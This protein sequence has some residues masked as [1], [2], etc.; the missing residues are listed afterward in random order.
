ML[1][2][3][4][5]VLSGHPSSFFTPQPIE[6]PSTLALSPTLCAHLHPGEVSSLNDLAHLAFQ[7]TSIR[8][9][10]RNIQA[11]GRQSVLEASLQQQSRYKIKG[12]GKEKE[13]TSDGVPAVDLYL[14]TLAGSVLDILREYEYLIVE[15]EARVINSD[16]GLVQDEGGYVPLS[17]L[18][19][20]FSPWQAPLASLSSLITTLP[21]TP[22]QMIQHLTDLA[23]NGNPRINAIYSS[24]LHAVHRL[25]LTHLIVFLLSGTAPST[26]TP[27]S[28]AVGL[29]AGPDPLSPQ[30]RIYKLND[31]LFPPSIRADTRESILY[32]GRVTATLKREGRVLPKSLLDGLRDAILTSNNLTLD[33]AIQRAREEVGE[34]LWTHVLTSSQVCESIDSFGD[35]F[36]TRKADYATSLLRE[37][38]ALQRTKLLNTNPHSSTA[39]IREQDLNTAILRASVGTCAELDRNVERLRYRLLQGSIRPLSMGHATA[40]GSKQDA[41]QGVRGLFSNFLLG[42]PAT[43][44]S[45]ITWPLGLFMTPATM[46]AY[47]DIHTFLL[48][49]RDTHL[50]VLTCWSALSASQRRRRKWTGANEGGQDGLDRDTRRRLARTA[51]GTVRAM[52]FFLDELL[53]HFMTDVIEVQHR[54]LMTQLQEVEK[55]G[56]VGTNEELARA[57]SMRGSTRPTSPSM[58][59]KLGTPTRTMDGYDSL[60]GTTRGDAQTVRSR[61]PPS[62]RPQKRFLD[63]LSLRQIHTRHLSFL[64]EGLLLSDQS[65]AI[66]IRDI[67]EVCRRFTGMVE[68][69][70]GDVLPELLGDDEI[71]DRAVAVNDLADVGVGSGFRSFT[72]KN[73]ADGAE[74]PRPA[75]R[76]LPNACG[77]AKPKSRRWIGFGLV[78]TDI[79]CDTNLADSVEQDHIAS[80]WLCF[81]RKQNSQLWQR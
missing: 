34:W 24:L 38:A 39:V 80:N 77:F 8:N 26:S 51:W 45:N 79:A 50:K 48:A 33:D 31:D 64:R 52:L 9:W 67:L 42:A 44:S 69:W 75:C 58:R 35:Y 74:P 21:R 49:I 53:G 68:R 36:L 3:L 30:Y 59:S 63:F 65:T 18:V 22:G 14:S 66:L 73:L 47:T 2:E 6:K 41:E 37:V 4:L 76:F 25:F 56:T 81:R 15:T 62:A 72:L 55:G 46:S 13:P 7:Y 1:A 12:K 70:G 57:G 10:A 28:P 29:D 11:R 16:V 71:E 40:S 32:V 61:V 20:T 23:N 17:S 27:T 60:G 54:K 43:M 5:L 78:V 19:A